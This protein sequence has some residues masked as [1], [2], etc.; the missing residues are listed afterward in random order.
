GI[1]FWQSIQNFPNV[2]AVGPIAYLDFI[3]LLKGSCMVLTD[4]SGVQEEA[5]VLQVPCLTMRARTERPVT[6]S[7]GTNRL[8]GRDPHVIVAAA[9][10]ILRG[11]AK[12]GRVPPMWDGRAASRLVGQLLNKR[13]EVLELYRNVGVTPECTIISDRAM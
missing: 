7:R 10:R 9:M 13:E 6:V 3:A 8:V 1:G 5:T 12:K 2:M 11:D 4:T